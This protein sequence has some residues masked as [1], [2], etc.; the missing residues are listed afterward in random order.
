ML[1]YLKTILQ[2]LIVIDSDVNAAALGESIWGTAAGL[3]TIQH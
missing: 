2:V 3:R 1:P